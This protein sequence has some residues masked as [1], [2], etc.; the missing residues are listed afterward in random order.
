MVYN[1]VVVLNNLHNFFADKFFFI[2]K[3]FG[4]SLLQK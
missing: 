4:V 3:P 2:L 1:E